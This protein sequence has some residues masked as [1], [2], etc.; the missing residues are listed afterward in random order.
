M[1]RIIQTADLRPDTRL[2]VVDSEWVYNGLDVCVTLE[3]RNALRKQLDN[4]SSA[5]YDF[6]RALCAPIL[7]MTLRGVAVD[8]RQRQ[9]VLEQTK[10]D[11]AFVSLNLTKIIRDGIGIDLNWRSPK[12]LCHL[13]YEVLGL[14]VVRKR[15]NQGRMVPTTDRSAL[16]K[17]SNQFIAEPL[18]NHLLLLRDLD[19]K[20]QFLETSI[21]A[22]H[23]IRCNFNIAGT[24]T[25]RLASALSDFGTGT[26]LQ[27]VDRDLRSV[28]I[29]DPGYKFAN[30]D[31]EQADARNVGAICW[32]LFVNQ[33]GPE[34]AGSYLDACESGDLHTQVCRMAWRDLPWTGDPVK[35]RKIADQ[36]AYRTFSYRD[37]AKKLGHGTNYYGMP[38]TMSKHTKLPIKMIEEF[39]Q[40][41]FAGFPCIGVY[42]RNK[43]AVC[44][45][46]SVRH[47]LREVGYIA[48]T[49]FNRRRFF[50]GRTN[51]DATLREAIAFE[52]QSMTA[53]EIDTGLL[54]IWRSGRVHS[55]V[56]VHD[57]I[58]IQYKEEEEDEIIPWALEELKTTI[59]L[60]QG[61]IF[62]VPTE[63]K[64][65]WNWGDVIYSPEGKIYGNKNGLIK[66]KGKD[67]RV[68]LAE[69]KL[70]L[71]DLL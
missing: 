40:A 11:I 49:G 47:A 34:F 26:N 14:P 61:R 48:T 24:N 36:I 33:L 57:S 68:R 70:A 29:A 3:V 65:G 38:A 56:Q 5:T 37:L 30:L 10:K 43:H 63:A 13:F 58:L 27:N 55:L 35:D 6:S 23:R 60:N 59:E 45:H 66:W 71:R 4:T 39:Q 52:P 17:L 32:N 25:G 42:N 21:D 67:T 7:E 18:C 2:S 22:D 53:D 64:V 31:L 16:E 69:P 54:R 8:E 50:Y 41:Y 9:R 12:Q 51:E 15:N 19:K 28:F 44:W 62:T 20:R 1:A 46:N